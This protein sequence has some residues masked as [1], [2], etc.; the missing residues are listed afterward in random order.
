MGGATFHHMNHAGDHRIPELGILDRHWRQRPRG[1]RGLDPGTGILG[2]QQDSRLEIRALLGNHRGGV[3][4]LQRRGQ[5]IA[6]PDPGA[7]SIAREPGVFV[8]SALPFLGR[9]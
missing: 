1:F 7:D 5:E 6:L 3:S 8:D 9:Q 4:E 2:G